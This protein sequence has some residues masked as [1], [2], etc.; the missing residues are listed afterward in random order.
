MAKGGDE[1]LQLQHRRMVAADFLFEGGDP[2]AEDVGIG[3]RID[4]HP[5]AVIAHAQRAMLLVQL[6][7]QVTGGEGRTVG[8]AQDGQQ[9]LAA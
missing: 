9:H 8:V 5:M 1:A 7:P 6:Q 4:R 2:E 3:R